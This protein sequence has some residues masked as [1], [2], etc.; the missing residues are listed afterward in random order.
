MK[1]SNRMIVFL[2]V[3]CLFGLGQVACENMTV[4]SGTAVKDSGA[5]LHQNAD[6]S[7][8]CEGMDFSSKVQLEGSFNIAVQLAEGNC[9]FNNAEY[10]DEYGG[11]LTYEC[12]SENCAF[13]FT[14]EQTE[15]DLGEV[16]F[17]FVCLDVENC[18]EYCTFPPDGC[19]FG[20][21]CDQCYSDC[22]R[23]ICPEE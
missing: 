3:V 14:Q 18:L 7:V 5:P 8:L 4:V 2:A 16:M 23:D 13:S 21:K 10:I 22:E 1:P 15:V 9:S 12:I 17:S 6:I 19:P 20:S 11:N